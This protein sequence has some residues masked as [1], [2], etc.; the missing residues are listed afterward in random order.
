MLNVHVIFQ[1]HVVDFVQTRPFE[2]LP[3]SKCSTL[4]G[5]LGR[6][7]PRVPRVLLVAVF[8]LDRFSNLD[9]ISIDFRSRSK[10]AIRKTPNTLG[11]ERPSP[12]RRGL[13]FECS[14]S[15]RGLIRNKSKNYNNIHLED[16]LPQKPCSDFL[17]AE[18]SVKIGKHR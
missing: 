9:R 16:D 6:S 11:V 12:P 8:G 10:T 14:N 13:H 4:R 15:S 3:H 18:Q 17:F 1:V 2:E 7:A 5:G